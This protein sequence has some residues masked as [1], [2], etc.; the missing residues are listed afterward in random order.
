[1]RYGLHGHLERLCRAQFEAAA[2]FD[3]LRLP[4]LFSGHQRDADHPFPALYPR[5]NAPQAW[6]ASAVFCLVQSLLGLYP[7]APLKAL[8]VDPHLPAWLPQLTL[9]G[10]RVGDGAVTIRFWRTRGGA[11][12]YRVLERR[13][14]VRV[15]RQPSPWSLTAGAGERVTDAL[16]SLLPWK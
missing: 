12:D 15:L 7:Y 10:L 4:E 1:M 13:G 14:T 2:R 5:A 11:S 6:S 16:T 8:V 9:R 3:G